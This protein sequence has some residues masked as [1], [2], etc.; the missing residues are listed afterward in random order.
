MLL[1]LL[2][3]CITIGKVDPTEI[4]TIPDLLRYLEEPVELREAFKQSKY[5]IADDDLVHIFK[6]WILMESK[7]RWS[8]GSVTGSIDVYR[9]IQIRGLDK[10]LE[11]ADFALRNSDN[12]YVPFG[13]AYYGLKCKEDYLF[14]LQIKKVN[15]ERNN[16]TVCR[17]VGRKKERSQAIAVLRKLTHGKRGRIRS[18]LLKK[19]SCLSIVE[20]LQIIATDETYPPEYYPVEWVS[21]SED[22]M[23]KLPNDLIQK[24]HDKLSTKTKGQW[25]R[26][27]LQL[28]K[29][30]PDNIKW[31]LK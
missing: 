10:D 29:R 15:I 5:T 7:F 19:Y 11:I 24:L 20:K 16:E 13:T 17:V 9:E 21:I 8:G 26:F 6:G 28:K 3:E 2:Q 12:P 14:Y 4:E 23:S 31:W 18:E 30:D 27:A 1:D 25:K 22:D